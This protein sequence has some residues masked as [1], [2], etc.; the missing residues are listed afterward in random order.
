MKITD[1]FEKLEK[2]PV[3]DFTELKEKKDAQIKLE[4]SA[5]DI[6]ILQKSMPDKKWAYEDAVQHEKYEDAEELMEKYNN[7]VDCLNSMK[8][9]FKKAVSAYEKKY[10]ENVY[11]SAERGVESYCTFHKKKIVVS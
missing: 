10:D 8:D 6:I 2:L 3:Q 7:A 5:R 1:I 4:G 9:E 11:V